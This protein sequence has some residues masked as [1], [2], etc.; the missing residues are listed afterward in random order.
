MD[1]ISATLDEPFDVLS[2]NCPSR[3]ILARIGEKW[4]LM[5]MLALADGALRFTELKARVEGVTPKVLTETLRALERDGL[6]SRT[7]FAQVPP[8][9]DYE[10]T[11]L[12]RSLLAPV[13]AIRDWAESNVV[14]VL[15]ARDRADAL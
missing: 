10:L 8:R 9:V 1:T 4:T 11:E 15:A 13:Q 3:P 12:G 6:V 7:V 2:V 5:C 14:H